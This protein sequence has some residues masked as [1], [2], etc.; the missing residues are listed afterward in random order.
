VIETTARSGQVPRRELALEVATAVLYLEAAFDDL[1]PSDPQLTARTARLAERLDAAQA[2]GPSQPLEPW[3]E[4]LYR[5]VSDKQTMATLVAE[6]RVTLGDLEKSLDNFSRSPQDK[7][8]LSA[9]PGQLGQMRGVLALLGLDQA[10]LAVVHMRE[11]VDQMLQPDGDGQP[12]LAAGT[13]DCLGN[14][15]GAL[16]FL[17]DMLNYQPALAR[18][19]FVFDARKGELTAGRDAEVGSA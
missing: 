3:M 19:Q 2:G 8:V 6:L 5:Q 12:P 10:A 11:L 15:L 9:V 16:S 17:I 18:K 1:D 14:N 7:T 13:F 4:E